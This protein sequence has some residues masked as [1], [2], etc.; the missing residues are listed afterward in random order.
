MRILL[1]A[2]GGDHFAHAAG[3][4]L[5]L[6][7]GEV[8]IHECTVGQT[9]PELDDEAGYDYV[10]SYLCP[11]IVP[12]RVL[13]KAQVAALNFHPGPPDYPGIGCTNFALYDGVGSF[14][15][16]CHH[17]A[18]KVDTGHLIRVLRFPIY[19]SDN[20]LSLTRRC[21]VYIAQLFYEIV[22]LILEGK[23]LP[24]AAESWTR[25]PLRRAE[26]D[27]LCRI[28]PELDASEVERRI[29][30]TTY[31]GY[32]GPFVEV[33]GRRFEYKPGT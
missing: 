21:Y 24:V 5:S 10:I 25:P 14:G 4:F 19:E 18:K 20:V 30:A 17:M 7:A 31:P 26:L 6:H 11:H 33:A 2:K 22:D 12:E 1:L 32:P 23:P 27:A 9:F 15:V 16:T 29:R 28:T 8:E 3:Q 13:Q